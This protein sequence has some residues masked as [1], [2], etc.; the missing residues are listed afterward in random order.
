MDR[1]R[2]ILTRVGLVFLL[3]AGYFHDRALAQPAGD[4]T[5]VSVARAYPDLRAGLANRIR[6]DVKLVLIPVTVTDPFGQPVSGVGKDAFRL[7]EDGVEQRLSYFATEDAAISIG[8]LFDAS[9]SMQHKLGRSR[10][11]VSQLFKTSMPGDEF[12]L[13]EFNDRPSVLC[14][15]TSDT[16]R[17]QDSLTSI[18]SKGWTALF[19]AVY[20]GVQKMKRARNTRRALLILS[21]GAD[22][23]SRYSE[24]E[25]RQ[26]V[27]EADVCIYSIG[28]LGP[29]ASRGSMRVLKNLADETGGRLF[30]VEKLSELPDAVGRMNAALR[31]QYLL[32]YS[33]SNLQSDGKYRKVEVRLAKPSNAPPLRA[34]WRVGYYAPAGM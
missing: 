15:F 29:G 14:D 26:L 19:D 7:F 17:I 31:N 10:E 20:L 8:V 2:A 16:E 3:L 27:R 18:N 13:V 6:L 9:G 32:G 24:S 34:S 23:R 30:E 21:D 25:I 12:F 11:A 22:N 4:G 33:S 1:M 28:M 5:P